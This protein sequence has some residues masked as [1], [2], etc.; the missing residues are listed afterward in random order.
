MGLISGDL[1][2]VPKGTSVR[3]CYERIYR[4]HKKYGRK[5]MKEKYQR[6]DI[7]SKAYFELLDALPLPDK[8]QISDMDFAFGEVIFGLMEWSYHEED[9]YEIKMAAYAHFAVEKQYGGLNN[10]YNE[11]RKSS[12]LFDKFDR[13]KREERQEAGASQVK[14]LPKKQLSE[15]HNVD[16][17]AFPQE[18]LVRGVSIEDL[19]R[20]AEVAYADVKVTEQIGGRALL[21]SFSLERNSSRIKAREENFT[22]YNAVALG[23]KYHVRPNS[24]IDH[25]QRGTIR[26]LRAVAEPSS[27]EWV[28]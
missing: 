15:M 27:Q 23:L 1:E 28:E 14:D 4:W 18:I 9:E 22:F 16:P 12:P 19:P 11:S 24:L 20:L 26:V 17:N 6:E 2:R 7:Y 8:V 5:R 10:R 25:I 13:S 3:E 21:L